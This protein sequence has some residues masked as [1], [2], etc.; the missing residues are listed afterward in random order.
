MGL[1]DLLDERS[2]QAVEMVVHN[3]FAELGGP[4]SGTP[5]VAGGEVPG[6]ETALTIPG[7]TWADVLLLLTVV[8]RQLKLNTRFD[9]STVEHDT[10]VANL[11]MAK[12]TAPF[13][14]ATTGAHL[15]VDV[16]SVDTLC[17]RYTTLQ[18]FIDLMPQGGH[19]LDLGCGVG[20][21]A[22][23]LAARV[24]GL[25]LTG[26]ELQE[27]YAA[28]ARRNGGSAFEVVYRLDDAAVTPKY[29]AGFSA[30]RELPI[31]WRI[32]KSFNRTNNFCPSATGCWI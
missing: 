11:L 10:A 17:F 19:V 4:G 22:L 13:I 32:T 12:P 18:A 16:H 30:E 25:D 27:D 8:P 29:V 26:V 3:G 15:D 5:D 2:M 6:Q 31:I 28:L 23:C 7:V 21:A 9:G 1:E 24:P 14:D 20:A